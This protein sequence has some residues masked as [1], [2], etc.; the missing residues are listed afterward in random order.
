[1]KKTPEHTG[2][3]TWP[4]PPPAPNGSEAVPVLIGRLSH[5]I[6][7]VG[8]MT[9]MSRD[10]TC[11]V[12]EVSLSPPGTFWCSLEGDGAVMPYLR[13]IEEF[14][15]GG[16]DSLADI[17][18]DL[19]GCTGFPRRVTAAA[20]NIPRGRTVS[21]AKLAALAGSPRGARAAAS[22]MRRNRFPL[23]VPCHRVIRSDGGIGGFMGCEEGPA[24]AM[25]RAL[26]AREGAMVRC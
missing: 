13:A 21:Y 11:V 12:T 1:M 20:R 6:V 26:L 10:G 2:C 17:R 23:I 25:K 8:V 7:C 24:V 5:E 16:R 9:R 15:N 19:G 4:R 3:R 14:L 22:V 18:I